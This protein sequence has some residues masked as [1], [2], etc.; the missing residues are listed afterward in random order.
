MAASNPPQSLSREASSGTG[1][2]GTILPASKVLVQD[3]YSAYD[4]LRAQSVIVI[5]PYEAEKDDELN[6]QSEERI[7]V[8]WDIR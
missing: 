1:E 2:R 5:Y 4:I 6:Q 3:Q 7:T 8:F